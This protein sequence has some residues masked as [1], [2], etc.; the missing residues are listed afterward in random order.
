MQLG[1][2]VVKVRR[3]AD[4]LLLSTVGAQAGDDPSGFEF[5]VESVQ[6]AEFRAFA[7]EARNAADVLFWS[8]CLHHGIAFGLES[9]DEHLAFAQE[10]GGDVFDADLE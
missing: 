4:E 10:F 8:I 5:L 3:E 6:V 9:G 2:G 1:I 7:V